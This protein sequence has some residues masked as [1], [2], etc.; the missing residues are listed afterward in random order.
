MDLCMVK[1]NRSNLSRKISM[2]MVKFSVESNLNVRISTKLG[3]KIQK[4]VLLWKVLTFLL[5]FLTNTVPTTIF[6]KMHSS[7]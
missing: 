7:F 2:H 6:V 1:D 4:I 5:S 3:V